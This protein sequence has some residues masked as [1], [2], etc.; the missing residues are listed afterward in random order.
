LLLLSYRRCLSHRS[1]H[2]EAPRS[3][4]GA[5]GNPNRASRLFG[6]HLNLGSSVMLKWAILFLII[7]IIAGAL[8]FTGLSAT[9]ARISKILFAIFFVLFL[10][11]VLIAVMAG[12]FLLSNSP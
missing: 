5:A 1:L 10:L 7:S 11:V 6:W 8:G 3:R 9:A 4:S 12:D 2:P